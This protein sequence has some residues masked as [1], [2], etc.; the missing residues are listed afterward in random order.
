L[1]HLEFLYKIDKKVLGKK[2]S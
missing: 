1:L 2:G